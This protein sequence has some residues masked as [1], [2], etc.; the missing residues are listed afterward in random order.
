M[1]V[2]EVRKLLHRLLVVF[3]A[4]WFSIPDQP[5]CFINCQRIVRLQLVPVEFRFA[6]FG[7][8]D[9]GFV[10]I[11]YRLSIYKE[12]DGFDQCRSRASW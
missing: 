3:T 1:L 8:G 11:L 5:L 7:V 6:Q 2:D 9:P 12:G 10:G 4:A